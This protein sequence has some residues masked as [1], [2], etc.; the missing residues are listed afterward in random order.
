MN[1]LVGQARWLRTAIIR[2]RPGR[3]REYEEQLRVLKQARE[4]STSKTPTL[5]SQ[6]VAGQSNT[7]Y[8]I[9]N[10]VSSLGALDTIPLLPDVLG[11]AGYKS[12]L[13]TVS[14][15]VLS[16]EINVLRIVPELSHLTEAMVSVAPEFWRPKPPA[17]VKPKAAAE[18]KP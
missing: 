6:S 14:E 10:V 9:T 5:V 13:K 8:Y 11:E 1:Q 2:V 16:T 3:G 15:V 4:R 12:Y 17:A 7:V 18:A